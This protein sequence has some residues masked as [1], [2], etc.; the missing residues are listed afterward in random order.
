MTIPSKKTY[1]DIETTI[2]S[3]LNTNG[4][5]CQNGLEISYSHSHKASS[6]GARQRRKPQR[7]LPTA[8]TYNENIVGSPLEYACQKRPYSLGYGEGAHNLVHGGE[9]YRG[10]IFRYDSAGD[11]IIATSRAYSRLNEHGAQFGEGF[12]QLSQTAKMVSRRVRQ[13]AQ[14]ALALK[15]GQFKQLSNIIKSG[16]PRSVRNLPP[17]KRLSNGW[18]ELEFGWKPLLSD[19]HTAIDVFR[20]TLVS[21]TANDTRANSAHGG[22]GPKDASPRGRADRIRNSGANASSKLYASV[23]NSTLATLNDLGLVNPALLGWQLLPFSFVVDWVVPVS[24]IL[25]SYTSRLG[26]KVEMECRVREVG[27]FRDFDC[28]EFSSYNRAVYRTVHPPSVPSVPLRFNFR[29]RSIWHV[30]TAVALLRQRFGR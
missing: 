29:A 24:S 26:Y 4:T 27:N 17:G 19:I 15:R 28:G 22:F 14:I 1:I 25:S 7:L 3:F 10:P 13:V 5:D 8:M 21:G 9:P 12:A 20:N 18:L 23:G 2:A 6:T 16:V 30:S 11:Q